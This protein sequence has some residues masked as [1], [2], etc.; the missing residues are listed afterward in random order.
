LNWLVVWEENTTGY[1]QIKGATVT[2]TG[3]GSPT[4]NTHFSLH[5]PTSS[6]KR[7]PSVGSDNSKYL[8][9]WEDVTTS[10]IHGQ[11][12]TTS[13]TLSGSQV[14]IASS[15]FNPMK[16]PSIAGRAGTGFIVVYE[17]RPYTGSDT[18]NIAG[19]P[20]STSGTVGTASLLAS[21]NGIQQVP[22]I[23]N[24]GS[25]TFLA[26]WTIDQMSSGFDVQACRLS[27][28]SGGGGSLT[29]NVADP[30]GFVLNN[31][32][33]STQ[34]FTSVGASSANTDYVVAYE[35]SVPTIGSRIRANIIVP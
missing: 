30:N 17:D 5:Q 22:S 14:T 24:N 32:L 19:V 1:W 13:G 28:V 33:S 31:Q 35:H 16:V 12:V 11:M 27:I 20:V 23:G 25:T 26:T 3:S 10:D 6:Y 7:N 9:A 15:S 18:S 8:V 21:T 29:L 2:W 34:I 4:V